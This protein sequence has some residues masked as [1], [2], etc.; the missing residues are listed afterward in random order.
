[1]QQGDK[2][3]FFRFFKAAYEYAINEKRQTYL[4]APYT[5]FMSDCN[6][7]AWALTRHVN[8]LKPAA[9]TST[10]VLIPCGELVTRE[11]SKWRYESSEKKKEKRWKYDRTAKLL[12][13]VCNRI[14][15]IAKNEVCWTKHIHV[16]EITQRWRR[17]QSSSINVESRVRN[18]IS[19]R[20]WKK[21]FSV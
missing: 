2:Y 21:I 4:P 14:A 8:R 16:V 15:I 17:M 10:A 5:A 1:M 9:K 3:F 7:F 13:K 20:N 12:S 18:D 11:R 19:A 6:D